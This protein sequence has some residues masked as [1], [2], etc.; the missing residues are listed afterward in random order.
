MGETKQRSRSQRYLLGSNASD[1]AG[2]TL[3][4]I[5]VDLIFVGTLS[6]TAFQMGLLN[7]LGSLAFVFASIPAG[8]LVDRHSALKVLRIGLA[9]KIAVLA[10]LAVLAISGTLNIALGMMLCV[11]L[12]ICNV[13][14]ETA[15]T[16]AVPRLIGE[17]SETR[18]A[19]ISKLIARLGAAD[20][21]LTVIIPALAGTGFALLGGPTL[22]SLSAALGGFALM[23]AWRIRGYRA[24]ST[25]NEVRDRSAGYG[26]MLT[27][28]RYLVSNRLLLATT[29]TVALS[30]LGLAIGSSVEAIFIINDLGFGEV[31]FGAYASVSGAG[32][33]IGALLATRITGKYSSP[34]LLLWT[35]L[36]QI[37]L[38]SMVLVAAFTSDI[39]SICLLS[40]QALGW[41]SVA[42]IFNISASSWLVEMV[43]EEL[44]GRVLSARRLLTFG[45]VPI[46]S[47][48][49]GALGS[50]LG[51][52]AALAGWVAASML[53]VS[54]FLIL[55]EPANR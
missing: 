22:L 47:L 46:G 55:R 45:A 21:S 51:T 33:L 17:E 10:C 7:T 35:G 27:G 12:G 1:A 53:A 43:P 25:A 13:F 2:R 6:A 3:A 8:H 40:L 4:D 42:L 20:Q 9:G 50:A 32:G 48:L 38:A 26:S 30:N 16:A 15:Q 39:W 44:L 14:S 18:A 49:G 28:L 41:G 54:C 29:V 11:L 34:A 5:T 31:G 37:V 52:Q 36:A 23:L 19:G 24:G